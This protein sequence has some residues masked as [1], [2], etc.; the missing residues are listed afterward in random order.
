MK[1]MTACY[2]RLGLFLCIMLINTG[3]LIAAPLQSEAENQKSYEHFTSW[4]FSTIVGAEGFSADDVYDANN[5]ASFAV[6]WEP[7]QRP[8][9]DP[10]VSLGL[11]TN[12][13]TGSQHASFI[14]FG[15]DF[16][17][18]TI[19]KHPFSWLFTRS[20]V[21]APACGAKLVIPLQDLYD[22]HYKFSA[23][24]LRLFF[25]YGYISLLEPQLMINTHGSLIGW[26]VKIFSFENY[27]W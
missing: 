1:L 11:F 19:K 10:G 4:Q 15:I 14:Q 17:L 25:G 24:P 9:M 12:S 21:Y 18:F 5:Y 23:A 6:R 26:G 3:L 20:T 2:N 8:V 13:R 22:L 7:F 16:D 27:L